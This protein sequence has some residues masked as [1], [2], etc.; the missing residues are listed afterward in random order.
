MKQ[1]TFRQFMQYAKKYEA[2]NAMA[3][4][5]IYQVFLSRNISLKEFFNG[6]AT[7]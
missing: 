6:Y 4:G 2:T 7:K 1:I 3:G 5:L